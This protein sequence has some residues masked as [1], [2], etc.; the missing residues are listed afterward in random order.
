MRP[1]RE[2]LSLIDRTTTCFLSGFGTA[3]SIILKYRARYFSFDEALAY[4]NVFAVFAAKK[5][6]VGYAIEEKNLP[7]IYQA[8]IACNGLAASAKQQLP[9]EIWQGQEASGAPT[10]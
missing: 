5:T 1:L 3:L 2:K 6:W 7:K 10:G 8:V 9:A 4:K